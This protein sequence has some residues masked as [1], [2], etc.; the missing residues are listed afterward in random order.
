MCAIF[1]IRLG[2]C[3]GGGSSGGVGSQ[4]LLS[5]IKIQNVKG[6]VKSRRRLHVVM[7]TVFI[8][9]VVIVLKN[10]AVNIVGVGD[11]SSATAVTAAEVGMGR[12]RVAATRHGAGRSACR[13]LNRR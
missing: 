8:I 4:T 2:R 5:V 1:A 3:S 9:V 11:G 13:R 7:V 12:G 10:V 6:V